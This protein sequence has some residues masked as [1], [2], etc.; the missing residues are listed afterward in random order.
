MAD[1]G[2]GTST[3]ICLSGG[4]SHADGSCTLPST[5]CGDGIKG[6]DEGCDDGNLQSEDG[7]SS[8]CSIE[9]DHACTVYSFNNGTSLCY[10]AKAIIMKIKS[11]IKVLNAN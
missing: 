4:L 11:V 6:T 10:Y 7:C 5:L 3:C 1:T 2:A 8:V 9:T